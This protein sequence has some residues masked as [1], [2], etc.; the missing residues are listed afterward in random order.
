MGGAYFVNLSPLTA[1]AP[2]QLNVLWHNGH[3]LGVDGAEVGILEETDEVRLARLLQGHYGRALEAEVGLEV[4]RDFTDQALEWQL[5]DEE[6]GALLVATDLS[7]S[8]CTRTVAM[9][10][11]H[12]SGSRCALSG[13]L[14]CQLLPWSLAS[15][16][17]T[18][19]LLR[20]GH[21]F[22]NT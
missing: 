12:A 4:L 20:T 1:D 16:G 9:G 8:N 19:G 21:F 5:A 18:R 13:C 14:R 15:R 10:L 2:R 17:L 7:Q 6:L 11:L 22:R 3:T